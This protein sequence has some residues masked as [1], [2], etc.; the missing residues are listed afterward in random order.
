MNAH[1]F[2]SAIKGA[3][4][5]PPSKSITQRACALALLHNG[6]T[7]IRNPGKSEDERTAIDIIRKAGAVIEPV[8]N[9]L[10]VTG[11]G[12][13]DVKGTVHCGESGLSARMFTPIMGISEHV[14]TITGEGSLLNRSVRAFEQ[15]LPKLGVTI[16]SNNGFLP[17]EI[18][19]PLR[20]ADIRIDG[21]GSSQ[22]LT[23]ILFAIAKKALSPVSIVVDG[24]VS[25][26]YIGLSIQML[27]KFG[28]DVV[29]TGLSTYLVNKAVNIPS[30]IECTIESDWSSGSFLCVAGAIAGNVSLIGLNADSL[31]ADRAVLD[32][33]HQS[34][35]VINFCHDN[36]Q[37]VAPS[38][39]APFEYDAT[40]APDLFPPLLALAAFCKGTSTIH[41]VSRLYEK[42]SNRALSLLD[43]FNKLGVPVEVNG[44][45][46]QITGV[47]EVK[48]ATVSSHNDHRIV[49]AATIAALR[50]ASST[51][52]I[53]VEAVAKSYPTFFNDMKLLGASVSLEK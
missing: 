3:I 33:L 25:K 4:Q 50:S 46:M 42:E 30:H 1:V 37:I 51:H 8:E 28:Y 34:G 11:N 26:P 32:V 22:Y 45:S 44:N 47:N 12:K 10:L 23:G 40:D 20:P 7:L 49:M 24:L 53:G 43:V 2:P 16:Q 48:Q 41:G 36:I 27:R 31:Q 9:G 17:L 29:Q 18:Q 38:I 39:L 15:F 6:T 52:I 19:G 21:S 13:I 14:V 5:V 35:A